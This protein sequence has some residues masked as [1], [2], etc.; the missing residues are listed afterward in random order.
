[1]AVAEDRTFIERARR[2]Q[3]VQAAIDTIAEVGYA[4]ASL[5]RIGARIG[6]SK[7]LIGYHFAG[8]DDLIK[9]V[10]DDVIAEGLAY[11][12]PRILAETTG[13]GMLRAYIESNLAF[14]RD[15]R[16]AMVAIVEIAR[17]DL[18][19]GRRHF[20]GHSEVDQA[21]LN[22]DDLLTRFQAGA[23]LRPDFDPK[24]MAVAIRA[25]IDVVPPRLLVDPNF[26]VDNYARE[27]ADVFDLA[28]ATRQ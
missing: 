2:A 14:I 21:V 12:H 6:I 16:N 22:L 1:M 7:G 11:M 24:V 5:A 13:S 9:Q 3:I 20:Y 23:E 10:V 8:K 4:R 15:H 26:D 17:N 19:D 27:L 18:T 28:T 25:A